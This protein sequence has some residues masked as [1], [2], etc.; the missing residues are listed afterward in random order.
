MRVQFRLLLARKLAFT[1]SALPRFDYLA[2]PRC[3]IAFER[4]RRVESGA[5][6]FLLSF[7]TNPVPQSQAK[8]QK[9]L[10]RMDMMREPALDAV[11]GWGDSYVG[12]TP[13]PLREIG[14][15]RMTLF[16]EQSMGPVL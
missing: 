12:L 14:R 5:P 9:A 6:P 15:T 7:T 10:C 8:L 13:A 3:K 2:V 4:G 11:R 16:S 1:I